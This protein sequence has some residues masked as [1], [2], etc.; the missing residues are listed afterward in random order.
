MFPLYI[1]AN[2]KPVWNVINKAEEAGL[3]PSDVLCQRILAS[4]G[5]VPM[6]KSKSIFERLLDLAVEAE[7]EGIDFV[8]LFTQLFQ[9]QNEKVYDLTSFTVKLYT[10]ITQ[11][12]NLQQYIGKIISKRQVMKDDVMKGF[13]TMLTHKLELTEV[14]VNQPEVKYKFTAPVNQADSLLKRYSKWSETNDIEY[15]LNTAKEVRAVSRAL[16]DG[17]YEIVNYSSDNDE[18]EVGIYSSMP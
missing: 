17:Q 7:N 9:G 3:S 10:A 8:Y 1:N 15:D 18:D 5:V 6:K 11:T 13:K 16:K 12:T 2:N 14:R 4:S